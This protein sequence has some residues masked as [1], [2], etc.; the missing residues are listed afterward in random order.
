MFARLSVA[1]EVG[2]SEDRLSGLAARNTLLGIGHSRDRLR[3]SG[4][5]AWNY[6]GGGFVVQSFAA[7]WFYLRFGVRPAALGAIFLR[8]EHIAGSL[9][10]WHTGTHH[11]LGSVR[12]MVFT[13]PPSN[14]LLILLPLIPTLRLAVGVLLLRFA[15]AKW[16]YRPGSPARS[17]LL[18]QKND[19]LQP[20]S[21][22]GREQ[23][24]PPPADVCL[25]H[26]CRA[27]FDQCSVLHRRNSEDRRRPSALSTIRGN[28]TT[29]REIPVISSI[30]SRPQIWNR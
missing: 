9:L 26:V 2:T 3:L 30:E 15:S 13:Q 27:E 19:P 5:F 7:Y 25:A 4:L 10:C 8:S 23:S 14:I 29:R 18:V 12:T 28:P 1:T 16:T 21:R 24:A 6:F 17:H 11:S 22:E 20:A